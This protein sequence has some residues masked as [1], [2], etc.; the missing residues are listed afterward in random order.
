MKLKTLKDIPEIRGR[1]IIVRA[2]LNVPVEGARVTDASRIER[3]APT[4]KYLSDNGAKVIIIA[5]FGRPK[6]KS[7]EFS[8]KILL[9]A[10]SRAVAKPVE[11]A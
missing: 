10:L 3:F 7:P 4:A 9:P 11:F 1:R 2:D 6:G 8:N 5:H